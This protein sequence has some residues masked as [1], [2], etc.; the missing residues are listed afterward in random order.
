MFGF[1]FV[2]PLL[3]AILLGS[4]AASSVRADD[5]SLT[6]DQNLD[7]Y[8]PSAN[9]E[10]GMWT[11]AYSVALPYGDLYDFAGDVSWRGFDLAVLWPVF[12]ALHVGLAFGFNGFYEERAR[13]TYEFGTTAITGTIYNYSDS[14]NFAAMGRWLFSSPRDRLRLFLGVRVGL[15][16]LH[17]ASLL[18]D[19][20]F[21]DTPMGFLLAPEAGLQLRMT[22]MLSGYFSY[23]FNFTTAGT[24]PYE[25]FSYHSFQLGLAMQI[26][27]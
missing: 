20:I 22:Q 15:A 14:W 8:Q 4:L 9:R 3:L 19:L 21:E 2:R 11:I 17:T 23:Q 25:S 12:K 5:L 13:D 7:Y 6:G 18:V 26:G 10:R 24:G 16:S 1:S 27:G